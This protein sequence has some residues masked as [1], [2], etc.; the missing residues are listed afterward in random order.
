MPPRRSGAEPIG[1]HDAVE[2]P[3]PDRPF[4]FEWLHDTGYEWVRAD[5][6][7]PRGL[8]H[9]VRLTPT[10]IRREQRTGPGVIAG[11]DC[12]VELLDDPSWCRGSDTIVLPVGFVLSIH[13][14]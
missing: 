8:Y 12:C 14:R 9:A 5:V 13:E 10:E 4:L 3:V 1:E 2:G 6:V 11:L 7:P